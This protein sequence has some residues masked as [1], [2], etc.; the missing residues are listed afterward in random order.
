MRRNAFAGSARGFARNAAGP[1]Q[2]VAADCSRET[3]ETSFGASCGCGLLAGLLGHVGKGFGGR[4]FPNPFQF[5]TVSTGVAFGSFLQSTTIPLNTAF[6]RQ[7]QTGIPGPAALP[8]PNIGV[9][10]NATDLAGNA[11]NTQVATVSP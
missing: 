3:P 4:R 1:G 9:A 2:S 6:I 8:L 7:I 5:P 10:V 11:S